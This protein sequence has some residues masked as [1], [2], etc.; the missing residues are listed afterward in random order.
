MKELDQP[1]LIATSASKRIEGKYYHFRKDHG[2]EIENYIDLKEEIE[3][4]L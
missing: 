4:L 2:H 1:K 3:L